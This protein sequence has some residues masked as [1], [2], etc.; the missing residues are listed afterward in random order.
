MRISDWS[1]DVCSSD[2]KRAQAAAEI[3]KD[4]KLSAGISD[5]DYDVRIAAISKTLSAGA[6]VRVIVRLESHRQDRKS[7][8]EGK[9]ESVRVVIGGRRSSKKKTDKTIKTNEQ[10]NMTTTLERM[11]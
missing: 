3:K 8:V 5:H 7:V 4:I 11:R 2:L 6:K 1:S 10:K 9:S